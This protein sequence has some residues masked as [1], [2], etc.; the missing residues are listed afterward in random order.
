MPRRRQSFARETLVLKAAAVELFPRWEEDRC[1]TVAR[2]PRG[3]NKSL[4]PLI[5]LP[6]DKVR[7]TTRTGGDRTDTARK[8][9]DRRYQVIT[10]SSVR[11]TWRTS[12]SRPTGCILQGVGI[13]ISF[14]HFSSKE[15]VYQYGDGE[16]CRDQPPVVSQKVRSAPFGERRFRVCHRGRSDLNVDSRPLRGADICASGSSARGNRR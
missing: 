7:K 1:R 2:Y 5:P 3:A 15:R 6:P 10:K 14:S 11:T 12:R 13:A 4:R 8:G 9:G 16:I